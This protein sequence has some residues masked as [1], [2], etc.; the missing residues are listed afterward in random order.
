ML[1]AGGLPAFSTAQVMVPGNPS[2][3]TELLDL[4]VTPAPDLL[5]QVAALVEAGQFEQARRLLTFPRMQPNP[6][7]EVLFLS[8]RIYA[9]VGDFRAAADEFRLMLVRDASLLRPRLEL[10]HALFMARDYEG[11]SYH[12]QQVMAGDIPN[13]VRAKVQGFL[14]AIREKL[15]SYSLTLDVVSDSNPKQSTNSKTVNIGGL[16][17]RLSTT[18]PGKSIWGAALIGSANLPFPEDPQWFVRMNVS[19]TDF[20]N[21]DIDQHYFQATA[22]RR[23]GWEDN[24]LSFEAGAQHFNYRGRTLYRGSVWRL[25]EFWQQ[26]GQS[27]WQTTLQGAQQTYPEFAYQNGWQYTVT[28]ENQFVPSPESR[29]KTGASYGLNLARELPYTFSSPSVY[30]H[31]MREWEQG[32]ISGIRLQVTQSDYRGND[33]FFGVKRHDNEQRAEIDLVNRSWQFSGMSPRF[34]LGYIEHASNA[35]LYKFRRAY[36]KV[37]LTREF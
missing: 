33:P 3:E 29:W 26:S 23:W 4:L 6:H 17:Y 2:S 16:N 10:A 24:T 31:Y 19:L 21:K 9:G 11:A 1:C 36:V 18:A 22:G 32:L 13:D 8:G 12:F 37:G 25:S 35:A 7:L 5:G 34:L 28:L 27:S 30:V 20:P 14:S 15:P